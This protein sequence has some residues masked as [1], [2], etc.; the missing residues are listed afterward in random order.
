MREPQD[1]LTDE[2]QSAENEAV[3]GLALR[4]DDIFYDAGE[5][6]VVTEENLHTYSDML[7]RCAS[8]LKDSEKLRKALTKPLLD[9]KANID[10]MV[11]ER[12]A[13]VVELDRKLRAAI[14]AFNTER[15]RVRAQ[16]ERLARAALAER[17]REQEADR[18]RL[19]EAAGVPVEAIPVLDLTRAVV[20][21]PLDTEV[22]TASGSVTARPVTKVTVVKDD[23]VPRPWCVPDVR[24]IE[25]FVKAAVKD[26]GLDGAQRTVREVFHGGV[27][28]AVEMVT[29]V[30]TD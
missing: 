1:I 10:R 16:Q 17:A 27:E 19:A 7:A 21:E 2:Y 28:V 11:K 20:V 8:V 13:G 26:E 4:A 25:A 22:V 12:V 14:G 9:H 5:L 23:L 3:H 15:E 30:K 24:A 29:V 6:A 18:A